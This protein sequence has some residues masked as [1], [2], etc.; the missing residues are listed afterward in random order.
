M[1]GG[2]RRGIDCQWMFRLERRDAS[3][4]TKHAR[5]GLLWLSKGGGGLRSTER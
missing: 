5:L 3:G 4:L 2:R 1:R